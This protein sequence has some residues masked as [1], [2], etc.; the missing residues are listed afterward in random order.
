MVLEGFF[1]CACL[2]FIQDGFFLTDIKY[3]QHLQVNPMNYMGYGYIYTL[4]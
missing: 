3:T 4:V 2:L 1:F